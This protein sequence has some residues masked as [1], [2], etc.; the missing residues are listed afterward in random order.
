[1][2]IAI[3]K[4]HFIS[5]QADRLSLPRKAVDSIDDLLEFGAVGASVHKES[6]AN[7]PGNSFGEL[8]SGTSLAGRFSYQLRNGD[9]RADSNP[10]DFILL[11][12]LSL[13]KRSR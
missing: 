11:S 5:G 8:Q 4:R 10:N 9:G 3:G 1:M 6:T 7:R 2:C 12:P 13:L